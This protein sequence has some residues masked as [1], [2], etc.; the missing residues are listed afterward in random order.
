MPV[1]FSAPFVKLSNGASQDYRCF[2][3][4]TSAFFAVENSS[5]E[6]AI[7]NSGRTHIIPAS[8]SVALWS[9]AGSSDPTPSGDITA[10][11]C[12]DLGLTLLEV[13]G[14]ACLRTLDCC[15]NL[16]TELDLTGLVALENLY[17]HQ[18][19]FVDLDL[20]P[21]HSLKFAGYAS[22]YFGY[23]AA[24]IA[25]LN[26]DSFCHDRPL[27]TFFHR[28]EGGI[29]D[30][31]NDTVCAEKYISPRTRT[32]TTEESVIRD[33]AYALKEANAEA[34]EVAAPAMAALISGPCWLVPIP[35]S[36][37]S[38]I[39]NLALARAIA[40]IVPCHRADQNR[41]KVSDSKPATLR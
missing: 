32:I 17:C 18:N 23:S 26:E 34:I 2:V 33:I 19:P 16:L 12:H 27:F 10:L 29:C 40:A 36:N 14:L 39:P 8:Q 25:S 24:A 37:T 30:K 28:P 7:Y 38:L 5:G 6:L 41:P 1:S 3:A 35:A 4:T 13:H 22:R 9:C 20:S 15:R 31:A 21:C 11:G